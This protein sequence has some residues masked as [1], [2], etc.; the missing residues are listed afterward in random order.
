MAITIRPL[1]ETELDAVELAL[2][3]GVPE[4]HRGRLARQR[5]GSALYLIAWH[6]AFPVGHA[7]LKLL[8]PPDDPRQIA[9]PRCPE[10]EDLLV[11]PEW[12]S[13]GIGSQLLKAAEEA[14][15]ERGYSEIG[16][17][18]AVDNAAAQRLYAR[19]GYVDAGVGVF[20]VSGTYLEADGT[21]RAWTETC[22]FLVKKLG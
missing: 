12:R 19:Q 14:A 10:V 4:K 16:L 20:T 13:R 22:T 9:R 7:L 2:R 1:H 3:F 6:E 5:A 18:V 11:H 8:H 15:R 17:S 21:P